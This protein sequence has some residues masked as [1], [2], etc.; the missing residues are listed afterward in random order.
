MTIKLPMAR[1]GWPIPAPVMW[2]AA[3]DY[4][5]LTAKGGKNV[6]AIERTYEWAGRTVADWL[7]EKPSDAKPWGANG[8]QGTS[9]GPVAWGLG[10]EGGCLQVSGPGAEKLREI[11]PPWDNVSRLDIQVTFWFEEDW[12]GIARDVARK[13]SSAAAAA[14]HRPWGVQHINGYGAGDTCY[15]GSRKSAVFLRAYDKWRERGKEESWR[16][17]WRFEV[18]LKESKG[19]AYWEGARGSVPSADYWSAATLPFWSDRGITLPRC[20]PHTLAT[21]ECVPRARTTTESRLRW[22]AESVAP[23]VRKLQRAGVSLAE[24]AEALTGERGSDILIPSRYLSDA[25]QEYSAT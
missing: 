5:R 4:V 21:A 17:A 10:R 11:N 14:R 12:E 2:Y 13:S 24:I 1:G 19:V 18:E 15:I 23:S 20:V 6:S 3:P 16:H 25:S 22:L 8:Y 9:I 7:G